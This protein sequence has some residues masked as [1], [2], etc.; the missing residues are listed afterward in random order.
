MTKSLKF[1]SKIYIFFT[2]TFLYLPIIISFVF[3]FNSSKSRSIF[4]GFT[5]FWY[6]SLLKNSQ[7]HEAFINS[8]LVGIIA[9]L[10]SMFFGVFIA[11]AILKLKKNLKKF[12]LNLTNF[13]MICPEIIQ[14]TLLMVLFVSVYRIFGI[15]RPGI[16]T[17]I[18][19]HVTFCLPYVV[20]NIFP[21]LDETGDML[22][23]AAIDLGCTPIKAIFKVIIPEIF[24][25]IVSAA[26]MTFTL[27]LSDFTVSYFTCG[28]VVTLPILIFSMT[29]KLVSPEINAISTVMFLTIFLATIF[30][31][32]NKND[33]KNKV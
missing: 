15:F 9:S 33:S 2:I 28:N 4:T 1:I 27:S 10:V 14:G 8:V 19:A 32:K 12:I 21:K 30:T 13:P 26:I 17:L 5:L 6:N 20:L 25:N 29:R 7:I 23:D 3:S 31:V 22:Y 11:F 18:L 16:L 24:P